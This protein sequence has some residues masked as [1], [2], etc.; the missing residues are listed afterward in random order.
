M[1]KKV[2]QNIS[3]GLAL[4]M[5]SLIA[6]CGGGGGGAVAPTTRAIVTNTLRTFLSGDN[7]QYSATGTVTAAGV[8]TTFTGTGSYS[9]TTNASPLD[10]TGVKRSQDTFSF[11]GTLSN[12]ATFT[13]TSNGYFSQTATGTMNTYGDSV[14]G[15]ITVPAAGFVP[16]VKSPI[17]SPASWVNNYTQQNGDVTVDT[18]TVIGKATVA[19]GM[20]S[21]ETYQYSL[22]STVTLAAGGTDVVTQTT[23][24]VPSIGPVK[25]VINL[26]STD[27]FGA[28]TTSQFTLIAS[29]TNIA[30]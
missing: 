7:I 24:V 22:A 1:N 20:G 9:I 21:F 27:A 4:L 16:G 15:W 13:S 6:G 25:F 30:F 5:G 14:S 29:T 19:T 23:Y 8:T 17:T 18:E 28:V 3:V 12:G 2:M 10:L 11:S 26:T